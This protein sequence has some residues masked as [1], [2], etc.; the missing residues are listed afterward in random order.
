MNDRDVVVLRGTGHVEGDCYN[1]VGE[2]KGKIKFK[3]EGNSLVTY[4]NGRQGTTFNGKICK[5]TNNN[6]NMR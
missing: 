1:E 4:L 3:M 6:A 5:L 2:Q